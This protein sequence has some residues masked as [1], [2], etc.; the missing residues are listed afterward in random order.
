LRDFL[1]VSERKDN[2]CAFIAEK[3]ATAKMYLKNQRYLIRG[4]GL[5]DSLS[6]IESTFDLI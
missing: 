1:K 6:I 5:N 3:E 2:F 4:K